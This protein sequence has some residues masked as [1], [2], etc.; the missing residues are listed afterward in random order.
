M[1]FLSVG[2]CVQQSG[3]KQRTCN[4]ANS[5]D[6]RSPLRREEGLRSGS[7]GLS[8]EHPM[9]GPN[10]TGRIRVQMKAG[11]ILAR[12]LLIVGLTS[13]AIEAQQEAA[14]VRLI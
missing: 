1:D 13:V 14:F 7:S 10:R 9:T 12:A 6:H 5:I 8:V 2:A 3:Q 4:C 11:T